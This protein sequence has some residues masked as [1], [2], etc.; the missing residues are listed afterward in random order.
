V[1]QLLL[2]LTLLLALLLSVPPLLAPCL[3]CFPM[4]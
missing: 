1:L 3:H 2:L 4:M